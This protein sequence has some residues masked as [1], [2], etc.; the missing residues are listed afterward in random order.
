MKYS[1]LAKVPLS[2]LLPWRD[3]VPREDLKQDLMKLQLLEVCFGLKSLPS[4]PLSALRGSP[5]FD[6]SMS[7]L[8]AG[9]VLRLPSSLTKPTKTVSMAGSHGMSGTRLVDV[10]SNTRR[11]QGFQ[12]PQLPPSLLP[13]NLCL[14]WELNPKKRNPRP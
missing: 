12:Q 7:Y 13:C 1:L 10:L 14:G 5:L 2:S 6:L 3:R 9:T 4:T 11:I 8:Q